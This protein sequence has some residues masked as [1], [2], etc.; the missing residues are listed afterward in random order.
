MRSEHFS[1]ALGTRLPTMGDMSAKQSDP[2]KEFGNRLRALRFALGEEDP[3]TG[4]L[5]PIT[6]EEMAEFLGVTHGGYQKN[7]S[8]GT[9]PPLKA[10]QKL[11]NE[12]ICGPGYL[13]VGKRDNPP[14]TQEKI[15]R[16]RREQRL[17]QKAKSKR[18]HPTIEKI[19]R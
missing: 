8:I 7:E 17:L 2:K 5:E 16:A 4:R 3:K 1:P 19:R 15:D 6:Q 13:L 12:D 14:A 18:I 10:L 9:M 11:V